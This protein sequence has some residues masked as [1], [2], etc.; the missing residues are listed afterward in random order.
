ML[1]T[2]F[3]KRLQ[4]LVLTLIM[5]AFLISTAS[6]AFAKEKVSDPSVTTSYSKET[7]KTSYTY[8]ATATTILCSSSAS[9][10]A[11]KKGYL[12]L[13]E[14]MGLVVPKYAY[15]TN[16]VLTANFSYNWLDN[17]IEFDFG[18]SPTTFNTPLQL[19]MSWAD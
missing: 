15:R 2:I 14:T 9:I 1:R 17:T 12:F 7:K 3:R 16:I 18:P 11:D 5:S 13:G 19:F 4:L 10:K 8:T 6:F